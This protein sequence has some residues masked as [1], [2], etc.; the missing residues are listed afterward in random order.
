MTPTGAR[1]DHAHHAGMAARALTD[2]L[3]LEEAVIKA[4]EL[5]KEEDTLII[6]T[7]DHS[8]TMTIGAYPTRGN[9]ILGWIL[10][11]C[12]DAPMR[13]DTFAGPSCAGTREL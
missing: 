12:Y 5:T 6:V 3:A 10:S 4:T 11:H 1:I 8:H 9:P 13:S 7:A 2:A